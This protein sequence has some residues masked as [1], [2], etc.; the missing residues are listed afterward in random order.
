MKKHNKNLH[1][2]RYLTL[3][4]LEI[5]VAVADTGGVANAAE[6]LH[7]TQPS[8]SMQLKKITESIGMPLY[9]QVGRRIELTTA[10]Q[11][12][13]DAARKMFASLSEMDMQLNELQG[14]KAGK[15]SLSVVT[16]AEYFIPHLLGP[17]CLRYPNIEVDL[18][19]GNSEQVLSRLHDN[20]DDF[21]F[22]SG[23]PVN[24]SVVSQPF[25][26]NPIVMVASKQHPVAQNLDS[27]T[28]I[29]W[30]DIQ[31]HRLILREHG[32]SSR[33]L[34]E[35]ILKQQK[36]EPEQTMTIASN[37]G[38]KHAVMANLGLALMSTHIL[39]QSDREVLVELPMEGMPYEHYWDLVYSASKELSI[40]AK[41]F[42]DF[43]VEEG[44][45]LLEDGLSYWAKHHK[46]K[47]PTV[48][49]ESV[50]LEDR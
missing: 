14:M 30:A 46:P 7:L 2:S 47:L 45:A 41:T 34:A 39:N 48:K 36:I 29:S 1:F 25:I 44:P 32:S 15:L 31:Q 5:L 28:P 12:V 33:N 16:T 19:V 11:C 35:E 9:E 49:L 8:A 21:Y 42:G 20:R 27:N 50:K 3:R 23:A 17:F 10:G 37:E 40:V 22:V 26:P 4:Q 24:S 43:L 13:V 18:Q 6:Q 38:I